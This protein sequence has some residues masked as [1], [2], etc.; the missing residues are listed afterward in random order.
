MTKIL[1]VDDNETDSYML[2]VLLT[3][4]GYEVTVA[5]NGAEALESARRDRPDMIITDI[6]MPIMDG[7]SLCREWKRDAQLQAIPFVFYTATFTDPR[8]EEFALSLGAD[9]F[10]IKPTEPD[11]FIWI[12]LEV[13]QEHEAGQ[14]VVHR[15]T[16]EEETVY[17][18]EYSAALVRKL[19]DKLVELEGINQA[20]KRDIARRKRAEAALQRS[21]ERYR[22][23]YDNAP[24][25]YCVVDE[26][27]LIREMN[28]TQLNWLGYN[29]RKVIDKLRL[30]DLLIPDGRRRFT[31][32]L[33]QCKREGQLEHVEQTLVCRDGRHLPVRLNMRA[34]RNAA[35]QYAS[36]R[37]TTRDISKE[38]ELEAQLLQAQKLESLGTLA[39]G[40]A[41]DFNNVLT[42]ILGFT[43]LLL[44]EMNPEDRMYADLQKIEV[45]SVRAAN[46]VRQL[47]T[48]SRHSASQKTS[49]SLQS[50]LQEIIKLLERL[51][52]ENI[53]IE[54]RL[55]AEDVVVE[56]DPTQL[57]QVIINLAVNARDAMPEGGRLVIETARV[58]LDDAFCQ[59][60]PNL[61][62]GWSALVS[63][64]DTGVGIPPE[65]RPY[66]F[67]PFYTTKG[68]GQGTG[69]GLPVVY[70]IVR[71]HDG[72]IEVESRVNSGTTVKIYLPLSEQ[73]VVKEAAPS[74]DVLAGTETIL[75]VEDEPLVLEFGRAALEYLGYRVLAAQDGVEALEVFQ[76]HQDEIALVI[77]DV[78]M[79]RLGGRETAREL[80]RRKPTVAVLLATGYGSPEE[81]GA[82]LGETE[83]YDLLWKPYRIRE[84]AQAVRAALE[85]RSADT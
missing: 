38:K 22:D 6:M 24:D 20:L 10:I 78:V 35:G 63:V 23:L 40:I 39:G 67:D 59:A 37:V 13:I 4:H 71:N 50:F 27:G 62:P 19:E 65:I 49:L 46:M 77:L 56:A 75:L 73:P 83:V 34:V 61:R 74:A 84:L 26:D 41:H 64:S 66:I 81:A 30:E 1:V 8:D 69:L 7:F 44:Q 11:V 2:R 32:L 21:E 33:D 3:T 16:G 85:H 68:M 47:M 5:A 57:Q 52:P 9:R 29:R 18:K 82:Q 45:L 14:L 55:A 31:Q 15:E 58:E 76:A 53:K 36:Y 12:L 43:E 42:G 80:K 25:G 51:I 72:A 17:L 28:A 60:H 79:P 54:L 70:G 48:F